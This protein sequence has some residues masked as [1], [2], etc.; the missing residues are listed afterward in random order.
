MTK[1]LDHAV[2]AQPIPR[3]QWMKRLRA[4]GLEDDKAAMWAEMQDGFNSGH[5]DFG[6]PGTEQ[7]PSSTRPEEVFATSKA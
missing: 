4:M 3:D 7:V 6:V 2:A 5:I 1:V